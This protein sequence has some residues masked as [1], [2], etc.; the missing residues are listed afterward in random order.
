MKYLKQEVRRANELRYCR[1]C[2]KAHSYE[3]TTCGSILYSEADG[4][5]KQA[6]ICVAPDCPAQQRETIE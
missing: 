3:N 4:R 5:S 6:D 1:N 2:Y